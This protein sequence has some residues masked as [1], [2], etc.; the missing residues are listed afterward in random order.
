LLARIRGAAD[1]EAMFMRAAEFARGHHIES[2]TDAGPLFDNPPPGSDPEILKLLRQMYEAGSW[3]LVES[4]IADLPSD[5]R[6]LYESGAVTIDQLAAIHCALGATSTADLADAAR[7]HKLRA[8]PGV[9]AAVEDAVAAA[10]PTLRASIPRVPLGRATAIA[11]AMLERLRPVPG[12][13]WALPA[14]SL[15]RGQDTVGDIELVAST[16]RPAEAIEELLRLP[17]PPHVLHRSERQLYVLIDRLQVGIRL[18]EPANAGATLLHLTGSAAHF[19]A[20]RAHAAAAGWRLTANGLYDGDGVFRP[21]A[22]EDE[23]YAALGLPCIPPEIRNGDQEIVRGARGDLPTLVAL[24]DIRGDLHM[25]STWSD[26]RDLIA[27]MVEG[28]RALGYEYMAITDHSP[29]SAATRNLTADGVRKQA[30]E[31]ARAREEHPDIGILHGCEV[32]ILAD[33]RLDFPEKILER[34]DIVLASLHEGAGHSPE[35]LMKRYESAMKHPL[36]TI[37]THPTNRIV[38]HRPGYDL[39]YDRLF[40]LAVETRTVLEIDGAPQHLDLDGALARR[41]VAA[42]VTVAIDSD[43]HRAEMLGRQMHL[44][45]ITARRGWVEPQHV[46][47][48]RSLQD[49]RGHIAAKRGAR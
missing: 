48:T 5:L 41:A 37:I 2:D 22:T 11:D 28:C 32:D 21:M 33:G 42:G 31:I 7:A 44:G 1:D 35:Q 47:N 46:L 3:V 13:V 29:H 20:L 38:P 49:V 18:P 23:I 40:A 25:H 14:G 36:V 19:D 45:V 27:A 12:L 34:F 9:D 6:W 24:G 17:E 8:L 10:V 26:G 15:R 4:A 39:D 16:D 43:C 30:D